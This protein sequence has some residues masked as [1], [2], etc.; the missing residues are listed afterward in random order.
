MN[1][2]DEA[3]LRIDE[4]VQLLGVWFPAIFLAQWQSA[5]F[6]AERLCNTRDVF[7]ARVLNHNV[8]AWLDHSPNEQEQRLTCPQRHLYILGLES[9]I[10]VGNSPAQ[11]F[12]ARVLDVIKAKIEV[13][14]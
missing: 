12:A 14:S 8:L 7:V 13:A 1:E 5:H 2:I 6:E 9:R 10:E 4:A 3:R 11:A